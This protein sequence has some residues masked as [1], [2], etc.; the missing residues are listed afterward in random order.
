VRRLALAGCVLIG[1]G[2][3][4]AQTT[5]DAMAQ[6]SVPAS[7]ITWSPFARL[8]DLPQTLPASIAPPDL[9]GAPNPRIG[10]WW[11]VG[12]PGALPFEVSERRAIFRATGGGTSGSYRRAL[13]PDDVTVIQASALAWSPIA[14]SGGAAGAVLVDQERAGAMPFATTVLPYTS[15]PFVVTDTTVPKERRVRARVEGSFAWRVGRV[16]AGVA[17]G[18]EES[19]E[20]TVD[21][22]FPHIGRTSTPAVRAGLAFAPLAGLRLGAY[23][24]WIAGSET[25]TLQPRTAPGLVFLLAGYHDPDSTAVAQLGG[26]FRRSQRSA[27]SGGLAAA[28]SMLGAEWVLFAERAVRHDGHFSVRLS[29]PPTDRWDANGWTIGAAAQRRFGGAILVTAHGRWETLHGEG[30]LADLTGVVLRARESAL[31]LSGEVRY[32]PAGSEWTA[33]ATGALSRVHRDRYDFIV[34]VGS[35]LVQWTPSAALALARR[36][37]HTSVAVAASG[38]AYSAVGSIPDASQM[39]PVYQHLVASSMA[40]AATRARPLVFTLSVGQHLGTG[41]T[42]LLDGYYDALVRSGPRSDLW[43]LPEGDRTT[44]SVSARV[45]VAP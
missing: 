2:S 40:V 32:A 41:T 38:A 36:I 21:S 43:S 33:T 20:R 19:D 13:D 44:W 37:G 14:S 12:I 18:V 4:H 25:M 3:L 39:G 22:R 16:G 5:A 24:R 9:L 29:N 10:L 15:D 1:A 7:L 6:R 11:T 42:L 17:A 35:D 8:A 45:V 34:E 28:G 26:F 27:R 23:G 30:Q 31:V